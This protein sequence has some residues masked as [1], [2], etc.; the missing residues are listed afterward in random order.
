MNDIYLGSPTFDPRPF[1][2]V[3]AFARH[4]GGKWLATNDWQSILPPEGKVFAPSLGGFSKGEFL[5]FEIEPN[6]RIE[7]NRDQFLVASP[8]RAIQV[9]DLRAAGEEGARR[10]LVENG[11]LDSSRGLGSVVVA[12]D[13]NR[14]VVPRMI[15]HPSAP[16]IVVDPVGLEA[17][18]VYSFDARVLSGD[19]IAG[20]WISVPHVTVGHEIE[21]LNWSRDS[22]F[23]ESLLRRL[24]RIAP[25]GQPI[26][27]AQIQQ[28]VSYVTKADLLPSSMPNLQ[29]TLKR[30]T[31]FAPALIENVSALDE[32]VRLVETFEPVAARLREKRI[33]IEKE[34]REELEPK[35]R[36]ELSVATASLEEKKTSLQ[37]EIAGLEADALQLQSVM[38]RQTKEV[39]EGKAGLVDEISKLLTELSGLPGD[40]EPTIDDLISNLGSRLRDVAAASVLAK[41]APP[42]SK[43]AL[44]NIPKDDWAGFP[45]ALDGIAGRSGFPSVDLTIADIAARSGLL[46]VVPEGRADFVHWYATVLN[47]GDVI[48]YPLDPSILGLDDVWAR[49]A[50]RTPTPFARAW[51]AARL[52]PD[53]FVIVFLDGIHR[54]PFDLWMPSLIEILGE[55]ERPANLLLFGS[56]GMDFIDSRRIW[57]RLAETTVALA[58][59]QPNPSPVPTNLLRPLRATSFDPTQVPRPNQNELLDVVDRSGQMEISNSLKAK[60][61]TVFAATAPYGEAI[62]RFSTSAAIVGVEPPASPA[63]EVCQR[64]R[65]WLRELLETAT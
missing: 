27:R 20:H 19:K 52:R 12:L 14:C 30:L 61:V 39:S 57:P 49:P 1:T 26:T 42:W 3:E 40:V 5:T 62:D 35:V 60:L 23:L 50:D 17:L 64:G 56:I 8:Q 43:P 58:P 31:T 15:R 47:G 51:S 33:L 21:R 22:D 48:R 29:P 2:R 44:L 9:V 41:P 10:M 16:R 28:L 59:D 63:A 6:R 37:D 7:N 36:E 34:L 46:V 11:V 55:T 25:Q 32:I 4:I 45:K 38:D 65:K 18:P 13:D 54:T 24:R 53:R